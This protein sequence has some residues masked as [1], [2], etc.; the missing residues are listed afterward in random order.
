MT[1]A[2]VMYK[3]LETLATLPQNTPL[4]IIN[5]AVLL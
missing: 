5:V 3:N 4:Q 1:H 2:V